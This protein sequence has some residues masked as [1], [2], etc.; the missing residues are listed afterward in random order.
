MTKKYT[1]LVLLNTIT[2][3]FM[4]MVNYA[5]ATH[6]L[7]GVT[8]ADISH[9][10]DTLFTPAGYAFIIWSLIYL[11]CTGFV[12][13]QWVLLK[14][15]PKKYIQRTGIWFTVSNIANALWCYSWV[16]EWLGWSVAL[17]FILLIS[18]IMLTIKLRLE[19]DDEPVRTIFFIWWPICFYTGWIITATVACVAS[20]L[21]YAGW[22]GFGIS[23]D[24]WAVIM[25]AVAFFIYLFLNNKRNMRE[26]ATVGIWAFIAI[27][28]R[29]WNTYKDVALAA[30]FASLVLSVLID[31]H[32]YQN[33]NYT[34]FAK[35][36]R[37]EWK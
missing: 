31:I 9:T 6:L 18:L 25:I 10:Y 27:A 23:Q 2:F 36:K 19:L 30:I 22:N 16:H 37:G 15:D 24:I 33:R 12:I 7:A 32:F 29:Q 28:V 8:V 13:Y 1:P 5:S 21:V 34:P 11:L 26:A 35:I 17:I 3:V 20:W 4:L 14:N